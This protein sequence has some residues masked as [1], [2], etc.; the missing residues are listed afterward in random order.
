M[1]ITKKGKNFYATDEQGRGGCINITTGVCVGATAVFKALREHLEA[2]NKKTNKVNVSDI[3]MLAV[4]QNQFS[5]KTIK[6][7]KNNSDFR[8]NI[9]LSYDFII[10][11][12]FLTDTETIKNEAE[13]TEILKEIEDF[14]SQLTKKE[15]NASY[16]LFMKQ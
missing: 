15:L 5:E 10:S 11:N 7:L 1:K 16:V 13:D 2:H 6:L 14:V 8:D 4:Y 9:D 12:G 3:G